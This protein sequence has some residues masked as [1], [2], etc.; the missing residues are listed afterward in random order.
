MFVGTYVTVN[1]SRIPYLPRIE[2]SASRLQA[3]GPRTW[4]S[5]RRA[6]THRGVFEVMPLRNLFQVLFRSLTNDF[7][8]GVCEM[9]SISSRTSAEFRG[10]WSSSRC[11]AVSPNRSRPTG[12]D[13]ALKKLHDRYPE[14]EVRAVC[15]V[16]IFDFDSY[17]RKNSERSFV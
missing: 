9:H 6:I 8:L 4:F 17:V 5:Q 10:G 11:R 16:P 15:S 13:T 3:C 12:R 2:F 7:E 14:F 1:R